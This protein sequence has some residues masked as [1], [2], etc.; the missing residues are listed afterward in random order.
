MA[1]YTATTDMTLEQAITNGSM[2][3][4]ENLTIN[5]NAVVTCT[6]SPS[7]LIGQ[8]DIN[9]GKLLIDGQNISSGNVI[10]FTGEEKEEINVNAQGFLQVDG[11]W[12]SLGT[13]DGTDSQV[14][15]LSSYWGGSLEDVI[16]AIWVET[17]RRI[18]FNNAS[19]TLPEVND[20]VNLS[21][22]KDIFGRIIE[23]NGTSNYLVV[24]YLTGSLSNHDGIEVIKLVDNNG[25]DYQTTWSA[26]VN[27]V[28]G[29][30][31]ESGIYQEF[32]NA[33][34]NGTNCLSYMGHGV[35]GFVFD[36]EFQTNTL[37]MGSSIGTH[38]G[39]VP[40]SGCDV[41]VPNVHLSTSDIT[42][43]VLGS[44]IHAGGFYYWYN[45]EAING[46]EVAFSIC[47]FGLAYF[48]CSGATSYDAV[49]CGSCLDL[50][51]KETTCDVTISNC[52]VVADPVSLTYDSNESFMAYQVLGDLLI[53][54]CLVVKSNAVY[55]TLALNTCSGAVIKNGISTIG[56]ASSS[57]SRACYSITRSDNC[58]IDNCIAIGSNQY[59]SNSVIVDGSSAI[60]IRNLIFSSTQDYTKSTDQA[61]VL[62][63]LNNSDRVTLVGMKLLGN[64]LS[65]SYPFYIYNANN[66]KIRCLSTIDNKIDLE[67]TTPN[68][69]NIIG[70]ARGIDLARIWTYNAQLYG[71]YPWRILNN[72]LMNTDISISNCSGGYGSLYSL[73]GKNNI[74]YKGVH[75]GSNA[76]GTNGGIGTSL[77]G[78]YGR[79][80]HDGFKSDTN[81][82]ILCSFITPSS[83]I[84]NITIVR[85]NPKFQ[86][87]GHVNVISGDEF[88]VEQ[89]YFTVGHTAFTGEYT[90]TLSG[91][92]WYADEYPNVDVDFQYD[93]G[94]GYNGSWLDA[95]TPLNWV[96]ISG[97]HYFDYDNESNG[98]FTVGEIL[99]W[100]TG[101][102]A[103]T[104]L[105]SYF[106]DEGSTG[107]I[108]MVLI[109]GEPP[110]DSLTVTGGT[111]S[112]TCTV[113]ADAIESSNIVDGIKL[114]FKF[115]CNAAY[116]NMFSFIPDTTTSLS[117]QSANFYPIDQDYV[118]VK[119]TAK[120]AS[121]NS[122]ID[123]A[124][125]YL[126]AD[127]GGPLTEG[128]VIFNELT[129]PLGYVQNTEFLYSADQPI[130]G[131]IR[132]GTNTPYFKTINMEG[133]ITNTGLE[134]TNFM[135]PDEG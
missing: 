5:S 102:T 117:A 106:V 32:G 101:A 100:G 124:R 93:T 122:V 6:E 134:L 23:V 53:E 4:G 97:S 30:V 109:S 90:A 135:I 58:L 82:F 19:G 26:E 29:D 132:Q 99:S 21:S 13:T 119:I 22:D 115:N 98:P 61:R 108:S 3:N 110:V 24:K 79:Q 128:T 46:G 34:A 49:Y 107:S 91:A 8:V 88:I 89:D 68:L 48:G 105:I 133:I 59:N 83:T 103:G 73:L 10:N 14:F 36:N 64:G 27:N 94:S 127:A 31:K 63:L 112:A 120:S 81:G 16:P 28:S 129:N 76:I 71:G 65:I 92:A 75:G 7:V 56:G 45:L 70:T 18:D 55:S 67:A 62:Y 86:K 9:D 37:T 60:T 39:F 57:G 38:G 125:V 87:N 111:S 130:I 74:A 44:T 104:G 69:L 25:P 52:V 114:K 95:R 42:N 11:G 1:N 17:G 116:N 66:T 126:L 35:G 2:V 84:D 113:N 47:N 121:D 118:T 77:S 80:V 43:F 15:S 123:G 33:R 72:V 20:W 78:C 85:G 51:C 12:Y 41:K 50:G 54:D 96:S 131:Y 40:P